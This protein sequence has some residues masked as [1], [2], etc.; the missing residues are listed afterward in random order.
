MVL[1]KS[2]LAGA[3]ALMVCL[4]IGGAIV[5]KLLTPLKMTVIP[6]DGSGFVGNSSWFSVPILPVL[7]GGLSVFLG[8]FYWTFKRYS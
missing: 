6:T 1:A 5:L 2:L 8:A 4:L 3:T 7:I